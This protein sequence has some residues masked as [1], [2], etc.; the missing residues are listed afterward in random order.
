MSLLVPERVAGAVNIHD[1]SVVK[2]HLGGAPIV[3]FSEISERALDLARKLTIALDRIACRFT[4]VSKPGKGCH[5]ES[6]DIQ[7]DD[8][9]AVFATPYALS[10]GRQDNSGSNY[11]RFQHAILR[12]AFSWQT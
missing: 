2:Q 4:I 3:A 8:A 9:F 12:E 7:S 5:R 11:K 6:A 1:A 10:S